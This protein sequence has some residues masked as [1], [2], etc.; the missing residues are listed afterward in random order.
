VLTG[1]PRGGEFWAAGQK[2]QWCG[3]LLRPAAPHNGRGG[4]GF[5]SGG[6]GGSYGAVVCCMSRDKHQWAAPGHV[7]VDDRAD[8]GA[9]WAARGG[10]FVHH[11]SLRRTLRQL[12]ALGCLPPGFPP[13]PPEAAEGN[14]HG[15]G[16]DDE[17]LAQQ[18]ALLAFVDGRGPGKGS[19]KG[20]GGGGK[21]GGGKGG[22]GED[23]S[24]RP[25]RSGG[26]KPPCAFF[27]SAKGCH[28]G[29]ACRF[30]HGAALS[31]SA[32]G[33]TGRYF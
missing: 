18:A 1:L 12:H 10:V 33:G 23:S 20:H 5:G 2:K 31:S 32:G 16:A 8:L 29:G 27:G 13:V 28:Q 11:V 3:R 22:G 9:A 25:R 15:G 4:F 30:S 24:K 21:G 14:P 19:G 7:L 17:P 26:S 6:S